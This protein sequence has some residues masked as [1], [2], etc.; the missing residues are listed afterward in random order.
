MAFLTDGAVSPTLERLRAEVLQKFPKAVWASYE[1]NGNEQETVAVATAFGAGHHVVPRLQKADVILTVD[2]DILGVEGEIAAIR[3]FAAGRKA[4][5][6]GTKMNRL[7]VVEN[8]YTLTGGM[9]DHRLRLAAS[10]AGAF[11][12]ARVWP[13]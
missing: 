13:S 5:K 7:Y 8:R 4:D 2:R 3:G 9:S 1:P 11:L 6:P 12:K 10:R